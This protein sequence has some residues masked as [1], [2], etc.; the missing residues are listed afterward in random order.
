MRFLRALSVIDTFCS[1]KSR[2]AVASIF[3]ETEGDTAARLSAIGVFYLCVRPF[4]AR[5][6]LRARIHPL[7]VSLT[8]I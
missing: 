3:R 2:R 7:P 5:T 4:R 8:A 6:L 1:R